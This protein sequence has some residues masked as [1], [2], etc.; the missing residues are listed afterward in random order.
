[1]VNPERTPINQVTGQM[2]KP[3]SEWTWDELALEAQIGSRG[4]GAVVESSHRVVEATDKLNASTTKQQTTMNSLTYWIAGF[5]LL[6]LALAVAQIAL[7]I[8][9]N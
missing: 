3:W 5:T 4:Q 7:L 8:I 2:E 9:Q 6:L 1:M